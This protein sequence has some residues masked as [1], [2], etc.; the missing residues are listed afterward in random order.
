MPLETLSS[1]FWLKSFA[2]DSENIAEHGAAES[3]WAPVSLPAFYSGCSS[4]ARRMVA[5]QL[6]LL[7][8]S[9]IGWWKL[10]GRREA[11]LC[12][13][14]DIDHTSHRHRVRLGGPW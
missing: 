13:A 1:H 9:V 14:D 4:R 6:S 10:I 8:P 5:P 7:I 12:K 11:R 2:E 3:K